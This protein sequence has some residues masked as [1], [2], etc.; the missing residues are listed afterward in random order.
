MYMCFSIK[1]QTPLRSLDILHV[2]KLFRGSI[3]DV[4]IV[5]LIVDYY[6]FESSVTVLTI[7]DIVHD[8]Y[9]YR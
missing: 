6:F 2:L 3:C 9:T 8:V 4:P 1:H 7:K 5:V